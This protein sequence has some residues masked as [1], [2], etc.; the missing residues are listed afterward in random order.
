[1]TMALPRTKITIYVYVQRPG[2]ANE[3][4]TYIKLF[5]HWRITFSTNPL[6]IFTKEWA[7][8]ISEFVPQFKIYY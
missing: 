6:S 3:A 8:V 5:T 2:T 4:V 1:M 7:C